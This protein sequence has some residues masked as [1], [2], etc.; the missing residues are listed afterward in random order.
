MNRLK[1]NVNEA[2]ANQAINNADDELM[3]L[4]EE[5]AEKMATDAPVLTGA[6]RRSLAQSARSSGYLVKENVLD[7]SNVPYVWRQNFEHATM[8]YYI[9]RNV[10]L[11]RKEVPSRL[12]KAVNRT[13]I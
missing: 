10:N 7:L 13:W 8:R 3:K 5:L 4:A 11:I 1:R 6:L 9:T 12:R 2:K